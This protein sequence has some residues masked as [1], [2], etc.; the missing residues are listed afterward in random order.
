M[1]TEKGKN[2]CIGVI[3]PPISA[4]GVIPLSNLLNI[5]SAQYQEVYLITGNEGY[6]LFKN[7]KR[8]IIFEIRHKKL[9]N[10]FLRILSFFY[11]QI[12]MS[13]VLLKNVKKCDVWIFFL[14]GEIMV[15]PMLTAKLFRKKVFLLFGGSAVKIYFNDNFAL[16]WLKLFTTINCRISDKIILYS[17]NLV[18][19]W[20][21]EKWEN[22]IE[23][24]HEHI[25]DFKKFTLMMKPHE[26]D[27]LVGYIGRLSEEK[28]IWNF[29]LAI[30]IILKE[31]EDIQFLIIGDGL[32]REKIEQYINHKKLNRFIH[33]EDWILHDDLPVEFNKLKLI[34]IPSYTEGLPNVMLESMA[35]GTPVLAKS[36]GMI[37]CFI[38]NGDTG[39][40]MEDNSP[41][42]IA[43]NI[44]RALGDP[45]LENMAMNAKKLIEKEFTLERTVMQW[46]R[47]LDEI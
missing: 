26:R 44:I 42:C 21:L 27:N 30:D 24:A 7:D 33:L 6:N 46:K 18:K 39:F 10:N 14:G 15:F 5:L 36:I 34:V 8:I 43:E 45:N 13:L 40:I 41:Q 1:I 19:E 17:K 35:C 37:P 16:L 4:A 47:I 29:I 3:T 38:R 32:L 12:L 23:Y 11:L 25:I 31:R 20:N 2:M 28:G 9:Q 22:K